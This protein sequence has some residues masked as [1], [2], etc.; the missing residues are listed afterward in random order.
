MESHQQIGNSQ[1]L[2]F[3]MFLGNLFFS[4]CFAC[5]VARGLG[6]D[7]TGDGVETQTESSGPTEALVSC[8]ACVAFHPMG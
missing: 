2:K 1:K 6:W 3:F 8:A 7:L 4:L 5:G